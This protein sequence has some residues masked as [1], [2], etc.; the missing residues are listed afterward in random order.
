MS[1]A[2]EDTWFLIKAMPDPSGLTMN[3]RESWLS[4]W[5]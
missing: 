5:R 4:T 2:I 3:W 1:A